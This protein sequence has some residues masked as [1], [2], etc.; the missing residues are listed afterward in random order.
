MNH[1]LCASYIVYLVRQAYVHNIVGTP[2]LRL[3]VCSESEISLTCTVN[4]TSTLHWKIDFS[5]GQILDRLVYLPTDPIGH[6]LV[7]TNRGTGVEYHFNLT[8]KSPLTSTMSTSTPSDL[9]GATVSCSNGV[10][11]FADKATLVLHGKL[12]R[13]LFRVRSDGY[14]FILL[15]AISSVNYKCSTPSELS[16]AI[17]S[18]SNEVQASADI[19]TLVLHGILIACKSHREECLGLCSN[20]FGQ[21][22]TIMVYILILCTCSASTTS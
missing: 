18:C 9:S 16:G 22:V 1:K 15:R 10:D 11:N 7:A 2:V 8:S 14:A 4:E 3:D 13:N 20:L 17:V 21:I 12:S 19:A 5:S 6:Q